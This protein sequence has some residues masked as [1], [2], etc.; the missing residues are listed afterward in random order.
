MKLYKISL[1]LLMGIGTLTSCS[2]KL[3]VSNPNQQTSATFGNS[4][5]DL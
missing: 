2:D 3:D 4:A 1:A 5:D